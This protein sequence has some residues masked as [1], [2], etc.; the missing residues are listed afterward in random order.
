MTK[1]NRDLVFVYGT[2]KAG[3]GNHRCLEG[4]NF[5]GEG[6]T[7][8]NGYELHSLGHFPAMSKT[9][10]DRVRGEVY[11]CDARSL[12]RLDRLEGNGS[13]YL[14]EKIK[15]EMSKTVVVEAWCYFFLQN[16]LSYK[17]F[18]DRIVCSDDAMEWAA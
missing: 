12:A 2:L 15:I 4:S 14:R 6:V 16:L 10:L 7:K 18:D 8:A 13:L 5:I 1:S 17:Q 3:F 9:G 11:S